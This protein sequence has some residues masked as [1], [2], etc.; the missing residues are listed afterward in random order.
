[1]HCD[2]VKDPDAVWT[3]SWRAL[4]KA[5]A[6]GRVMSIGVSNFNATLLNEAVSFASIRPHVVQNWAEVGH[7]DEEVRAWCFKNDAV[8]Q[9]YASIRN[10]Q[11]MDQQTQ[12]KLAAVATSKNVS[13][14]AA[15][16]RFFLQ[17]GAA[18]IPR[19]SS[20]EHLRDNINV[21]NIDEL[22]QEEMTSLGWNVNLD[23]LEHEH[24][25]E[26]EHDE[27]IDGEE[28]GHDGGEE[29]EMM[30]GEEEDAEDEEGEEL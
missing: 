26:H 6:E 20:E 2:D 5:Y 1:M 10:L 28:G 15:S 17:T 13:S 22:N 9:P 21:F 12:S 4:E 18:L 30:D 27:G 3:E 23:E 7:V 29:G 11:H 16:L 19:S 24:E 14:H 8:Y 25:H